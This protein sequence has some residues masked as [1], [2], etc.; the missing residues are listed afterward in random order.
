MTPFALLLDYDLASQDRNSSATLGA[1]LKGKYAFRKPWTAHYTASAAHQRD[2]GDNP[3]DF[4]LW[5]YVVEP[6]L[7]YDFVKV[8]L[9]YEVLQGAATQEIARNAQEAS[10]GTTEVANNV[11]GVN[12]AATET[13]T[14]AT[15]VLDA[16]QG[17]SKQSEG[18]SQE[19]DKFIESIKAA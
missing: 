7:A 15:Q 8:S 19:I 4:D 12:Q 18:L 2:Y 13:G 6:G 14:A 5:Y 3:V 17:L 9:G 10:V 11:S 16:A 1:L